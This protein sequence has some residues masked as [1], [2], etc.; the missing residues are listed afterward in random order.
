LKKP[1]DPEVA[2]AFERRAERAAALAPE[3]PAAREPLEFAAGLYR[4]QGVMAAVLTERPLT[5]RLADDLGAVHE[6]LG[7]V[8]RYVARRGPAPLAAAAAERPDRSLLEWWQGARSG[9]DDY[10]A[11]AEL[12]AY[13]EVLAARGLRPDPV[14]ADG[15]CGFCGSRPWIAWRRAEASS[16]GAQRFLGCGLCGG[17]WAVARIHCPSCGEEHPDKLPVFT[18][19][20]HPAVRLEACA[21]CRRYVKSL[22]LTVDARA[23]PEVDDLLSVAMDLWAADEG[24]TRLEPGLAGV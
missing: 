8:R 17:A 2:L 15:G 12:R 10:L 9:S 23:V 11:R 18:S 16:E 22:D 3:S 24:Y 13:V 21:T 1:L 14:P 20:R 4:A 19:A 5:G 7:G 6:P